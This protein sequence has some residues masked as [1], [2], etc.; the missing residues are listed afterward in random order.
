MAIEPQSESYQDL[1]PG[2]QLSIRPKGPVT[3]KSFISPPRLADLILH[4]FGIGRSPK[5]LK[6]SH[7][8]LSQSVQL[9]LFDGL[10]ESRYQQFFSALPDFT[11]FMG[12]GFPMSVITAAKDGRLISGINSLLGIVK[13][14]KKRIK[15]VS[16]EEMLALPA[17]L[18]DNG[19]PMKTE[20]LLEGKLRFEHFRL[21]RLT[22]EDLR[23]YEELPE[24]VP[25]ARPVIALDCEMIETSLGD[26]CARVS[27]IDADGQLLIDEFF[28]PLGDIVDLRTEFSGITI[29]NI[30]HA[31][32]TSYEVVKTLARVASRETLIIGH[33][34]ENDFRAMKLVHYRVVDTSIVYNHES[35]YPYKPSLV[36]I[37]AKYISKPFRVGDSGHDSAEDARA[38]LELAS[39]AIGHPV[40]KIEAPPQPPELFQKLKSRVAQINFFVDPKRAALCGSADHVKVAV[41]E[42]GD[43]LCAHFIQAMTEERPPFAIACFSDLATCDVADEVEGEICGCYNRWLAQIR[44]QVPSN[45]ITIVY[46]GTGNPK[47]LKADLKTLD[48]KWQNAGHDPARKEEFEKCRRGFCWVICTNNPPPDG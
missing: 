4:I 34:L 24:T 35:Q 38:T 20:P 32:L 11:S 33:S 27:V 12:D 7:L 26:E 2:A 36:R 22:E 17:E 41:H 47:R 8:A 5:W 46:A 43:D 42:A 21:G 19:F 29:E 13:P 16:F 15:F 3:D 30:E 23:E 31:T 9:L 40:H 37:Y 28:K 1:F 25:S 39:H 48:P 18:F 14:P 6:V 45:S 10:D 44:A